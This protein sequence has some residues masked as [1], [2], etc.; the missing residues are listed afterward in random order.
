MISREP[1]MRGYFIKNDYYNGIIGHSAHRPRVDARGDDAV[2][3][4][5]L[6]GE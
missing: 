2:A 5:W 4:A 6:R 1:R 3:D